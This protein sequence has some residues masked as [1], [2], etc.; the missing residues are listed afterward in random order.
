MSIAITGATGQL[1]RLVIEELLTAGVPADRITAVARSAEKAADLVARGVRLHLGDYDRPETFAGA[2]R[3][4]DRVL[5]ISASDVGRRIAQHAAVVDAAAAA[6]VAQLAY[7]G[8]FGG[9][10]ADFLLAGEH[11]ATEEL[12]LATGLPYTFL[13]NNW[14][15]DASMFTGDLAGIMARGA[16]A[17]SVHAESRIA[18]APRADY[19]A[20]AAA[21][22]TSDAHLNTAYEL[23]GDTAWTFGEFAEMITRQSGAEV[24]HTYL[25]P[26]EQKAILAAAGVP[27]A[28]AEI[29]VDVDDAINR[30][31]LAGT[32]GD[33]SRLI[34]RPTTP[35]TETVAAA[36]A[37]LA[38]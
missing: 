19:A 13:R 31:A 22:L 23:S 10:K 12:I 37:D 14:Y 38:S 20:A 1:G 15:S 9:P 5:L 29:L 28:I 30:G 2:F 27:D 21:V 8:V 25:P 36:L 34:G 35:M 7:V 6:G 3:P 26:H 16:I 32:P 24:V 33:L 17:N 4:E 18:T 11:R